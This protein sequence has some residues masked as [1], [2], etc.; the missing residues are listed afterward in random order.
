[1]AQNI[2]NAFY[3]IVLE[4]PLCNYTSICQFLICEHRLPL[5]HNGG[6]GGRDLFSFN[7]VR[8][9]YDHVLVLWEYYP[10]KFI[11]A[12]PGVLPPRR[13]FLNS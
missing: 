13:I 2:K 9:V 4:F 6:G 10:V 11:A 1:M 5:V 3:K 12:P 7:E 8:G